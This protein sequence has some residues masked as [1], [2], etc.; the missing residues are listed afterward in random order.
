MFSIVAG[1][2][3]LVTFMQMT[4]SSIPHIDTGEPV[5]LIRFPPF[6]R[7]FVRSVDAR[8][9]NPCQ[10]PDLYSNGGLT[11]RNNECPYAAR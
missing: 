1:D 4:F 10:R 11:H 3:C 7:S 2:R 8:T 6:V 5:L 9:P